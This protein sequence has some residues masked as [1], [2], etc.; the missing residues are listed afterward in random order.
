MKNKY[1]KLKNKVLI[2]SQG[3]NNMLKEIQRNILINRLIMIGV[4]NVN[5]VSI[6]DMS[7]KDLSLT[8][9]KEDYK[10]GCTEV[11]KWR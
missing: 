10:N 3:G 5:E 6:F 4:W 8:I 11:Q 7:I 1:C 2:F 9:A